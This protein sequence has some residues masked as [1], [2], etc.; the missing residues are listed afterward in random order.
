MKL[1]SAMLTWF[2]TGFLAPLY[3]L[4]FSLFYSFTWGAKSICML[5]DEKNYRRCLCSLNRV[6]GGSKSVF[7]IS[8]SLLVFS[9]ISHIQYLP[10]WH[11]FYVTFCSNAVSAKLSLMSFQCFPLKNGKCAMAFQISVDHENI[12]V[13]IVSK[14]LKCEIH[15]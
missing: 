11:W 2:Q 8:S 12:L 13:F 7:F 15:K 3:S 9:L 1:L 14:A 10:L 4:I 6:A 5:H